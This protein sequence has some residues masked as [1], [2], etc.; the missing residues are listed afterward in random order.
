MPTHAPLARASRRAILAAT[1][2]VALAAAPAAHARPLAPAAAP[3]SAQ[4]PLPVARVAA[5]PWRRGVASH[6]G[7]GDGLIGSALACGGR[8]D[9]RRPVVAHRTLPCGTHLQICV[10][11]RCVIA[12]VR[13]RG[14]FVHGRVLDLGPRVARA[15]RFVDVG[16]GRVRYRVRG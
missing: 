1:A 15:L 16:V 8:L 6:Y 2:L 13:D 9:Q 12:V 10:G 14:P 4:H 3:A 11:A 5:R 7:L